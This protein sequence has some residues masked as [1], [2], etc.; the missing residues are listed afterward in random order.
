MANKVV[1]SKE[2][3]SCFTEGG[4]FK[5]EV[6]LE[7]DDG[8]TLFVASSFLSMASPVFEAMFTGDFKEKLTG[9]VKMTGKSCED[10]TTLLQCIHPAV[11]WPIDSKFLFI[12]LFKLTH[13]YI[14]VYNFFLHTLLEFPLFYW[15]NKK[16]SATARAFIQLVY[17]L[18]NYFRPNFTQ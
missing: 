9:V 11:L 10:M 17:K 18:L 6:K 14:K 8:K 4:M 1:E 13:Y 7:F 5:D 16:L 2:V 12:L 15:L 3:N